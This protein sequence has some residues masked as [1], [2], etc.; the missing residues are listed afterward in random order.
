M[1]LDQGDTK[2]KA[3]ESPHPQG[4]IVVI[5]EPGGH[6]AATGVDFSRGAPAGCTQRA[7]Q[8]ARAVQSAWREVIFSRCDAHIADALIDHWGSLARV[9]HYLLSTK[10][11]TQ[12]VI[13][14]GYKDEE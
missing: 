12:E 2:N 1:K 7:T 13:P 10:K 8:E 11:W 14:I 4:V 3:V 6:V 9:K 5:V